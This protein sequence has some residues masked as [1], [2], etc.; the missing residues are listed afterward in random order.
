MNEL[1]DVSED[2]AETI[3]SYFKDRT[4]MLIFALLH[5]DQDIRKKILNIDEELYS[6]NKK[7]K[8][9]RDSLLK[10]LHPDKCEHPNASKAI[11]KVNSLYHRMREHGE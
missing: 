6:S 9:W 10:L 7:A 2:N 3:E 8:A 11:A 1:K 5:L 4:S